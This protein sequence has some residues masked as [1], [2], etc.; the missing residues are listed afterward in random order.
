MIITLPSRPGAALVNSDRYTVR[1]AHYLG[2]LFYVVDF[3]CGFRFENFYLQVYILHRCT[4][5]VQRC[6]SRSCH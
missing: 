6:Q 2:T 4:C 5:R 1:L 3:H